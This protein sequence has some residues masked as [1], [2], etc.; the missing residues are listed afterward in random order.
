VRERDPSRPLHYEHDLT[1]TLG[2]V[3]SRMYATHAEVEALGRREEPPLEDPALDA[4]G[5]R[6]R[7]CSASTRTRWATGRAACPSTRR[8]SRRAPA[9]RRRVRLGVDRPRHPRPQGDFAYGG[10]FGEPLHD[11]NFVA[12]GLLLP[13]PHALAGAGR[14]QGRV[15]ARADRRARDREPLRR[16][17]ANLVA[18]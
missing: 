12:D 15:R 13:R 8:C 11:G 4:A 6:S 18:T 7:S 9:L 2:D 17:S 10:D 5:A 3:H 1:A 14:A 16:P